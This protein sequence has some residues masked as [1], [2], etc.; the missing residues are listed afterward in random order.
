[1]AMA[2]LPSPANAGRARPYHPGRGGARLSSHNG[3][4]GATA[5][6][7]WRCS[8]PTRP[9][10]LR[11]CRRRFAT[12]EGLRDNRR[13]PRAQVLR[14][15][16]SVALSTRFYPQECGSCERITAMLK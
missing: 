5:R 7:G 8:L 16:A 1:M 9:R 15:P 13:E 2:S 4:A 11:G 14:F 10:I 6:R 12:V 3:S